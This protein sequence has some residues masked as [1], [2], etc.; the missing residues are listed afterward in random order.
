M[1]LNLAVFL[2]MI[3]GEKLI[4]DGATSICCLMVKSVGKKIKV[5]SS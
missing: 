3:E 4:T 2:M 5:T 1:L